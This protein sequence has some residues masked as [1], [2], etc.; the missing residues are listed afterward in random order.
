LFNKY[1]KTSERPVDS[2][3]LIFYKSELLA[4]TRVRTL[5][6]WLMKRRS[7][8]ITFCENVFCDRLVCTSRFVKDVDPNLRS[9]PV[10]YAPKMGLDARAW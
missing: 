7:D 5:S 9:S 2:K 4:E 8:W 6:N 3:C 1:F 10:P